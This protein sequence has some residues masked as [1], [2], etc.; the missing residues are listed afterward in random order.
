MINA[1]IY[2]L[3]VVLEWGGGAHGNSAPKIAFFLITV[4]ILHLFTITHGN[5][6]RT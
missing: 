4:S 1:Y 2:I 5:V 3:Y 6:V